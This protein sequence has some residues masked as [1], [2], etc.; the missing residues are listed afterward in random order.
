MQL[1][2]FDLDHTLLDGDSDSLWFRFLAAR[3]ALNAD[4]LAEERARHS[5]DYRAGVMDVAAYYS[6]VLKPLAGN[7]P[8]Q[9]LAWR[10]DYVRERILPRIPD[11]SRALLE[12]HRDAGHTLAIVTATVRFITEPI[13]AELG[14]PHLLA[15][16]AEQDS[17]R[18]TGRVSGIPCFREGKLAHLEAW[19]YQENYT[20]A[21]T[22]FYSD[23]HNDLPLLNHVTHPVAVNPDPVLAETA[24]Q[25]GWPIMQLRCAPARAAG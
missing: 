7:D 14:V 10:R 24:T 21:E 15:T 19:L 22:W 3:G 2:L 11:A 5:R 8:A 9:L 20:P 4:A 1:A 16:E 13:A 18:F 25:R 6:L 17:A 23:S 12:R